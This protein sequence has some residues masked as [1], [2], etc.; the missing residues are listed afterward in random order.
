MIM[1]ENRQYDNEF[2]VQAVKLSKEI[3]AKKASEELGVPYNTLSGWVRKAKS[4]DINLGKGSYTPEEALGL[5]DEVQALKKQMKELT[6]ENK[7]IKEENEI[8]AEATAF[9]AASRR[10]SGKTSD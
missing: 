3:G 7:R 5:A 4:G 2:K 6:K 9:F 8:L 1:Q 10:K